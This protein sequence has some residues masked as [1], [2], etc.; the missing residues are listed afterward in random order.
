SGAIGQPSAGV[1]AL[2][3]LYAAYPPYR[4][5]HGGATCAG[6]QS[7]VYARGPAGARPTH[8]RVQPH[9]RRPAP[10]AREPARTERAARTTHSGFAGWY[11]NFDLRPADCQR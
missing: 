9:A 6:F 8:R 7:Q 2:P 3:R 5:G 10:R 4:G 11:L 1:A